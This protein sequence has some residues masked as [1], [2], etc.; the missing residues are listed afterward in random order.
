MNHGMNLP[1]PYTPPSTASYC[2]N[3][4]ARVLLLPDIHIP[5]HELTPLRE[6]MLYGKKRQ[7]TH[8]LLNGDAID[9]Y[10]L[11]N[12]ERDPRKL[13][14]LD[15]LDML[16]EFLGTIRL[17]FPRAKVAYKLGNHEDRLRRYIWTKAPELVGLPMAEFESLVGLAELGIDM[18]PSRTTIRLGKL[19]VLHGHEYRYGI[20]NPVNPARGLFMRTKSTA[21]CSHHHARSEHSERTVDGKLI[22][23]WSTGCLC[24][25]S[26]DYNPYNS[27][28]HGFAFIEVAKDGAFDVNN[29]RI[30]H[31]KVYA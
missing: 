9:F 10:P 19:P 31:G 2:I 6:A 28:S 18:V 4:P 26:P 13:R 16:R 15:E 12:W 24:N 8:I 3:G 5:F 29:L 30:I 25:L 11:S 22:T 7:P 14:L 20:T 27:W 17:T 1:A 23:T 21:L